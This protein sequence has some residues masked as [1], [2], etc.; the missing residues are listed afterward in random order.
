MP[1][2]INISMTVKQAMTAL[3]AGNPGALGVLGQLI[4]GQDAFSGE[5]SNHPISYPRLLD[6]DDMNIYGPMI[7]IGFKDHCKQDLGEF[8]KCLQA[9]DPAMVKTI[10]DEIQLDPRMGGYRAVIG[11]GS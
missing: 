9:R 2:R 11:G 1:G 3:G 4:Q 7:W 10:N 8:A 6:L 5:P